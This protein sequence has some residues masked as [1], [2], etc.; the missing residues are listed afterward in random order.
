MDFSCFVLNY[1]INYEVLKS[2]CAFHVYFLLGLALNVE[3]LSKSAQRDLNPVAYS[4]SS[5]T[6]DFDWSSLYV[7]LFSIKLIFEIQSVITHFPRLSYL[8]ASKNQKGYGLDLICKV[9]IYVTGI[10]LISVFT[11]LL[12][13]TRH[14]TLH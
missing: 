12:M 6:Q 9:F 14:W 8:T 5:T 13:T 7:K 3:Y 11:L 4:V 1:C 2:K 10:D